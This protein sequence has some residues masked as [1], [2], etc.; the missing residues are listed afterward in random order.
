MV[1]PCFPFLGITQLAVVEFEAS[2]HS[3]RADQLVAAQAEDEAPPLNPD[4]L[5]VSSSTGL[6]GVLDQGIDV[7]GD[8]GMAACKLPGETKKDR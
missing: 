2:L 5:Y 4:E 3:N 6:A 8:A 1:V 7:L